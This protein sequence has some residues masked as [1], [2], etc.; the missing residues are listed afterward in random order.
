[1]GRCECLRRHWKLQLA[2][3]LL[4]LVHLRVWVSAAANVSPD[5][6]PLECSGT[7]QHSWLAPLDVQEGN[8]VRITLDTPVLLSAL[9]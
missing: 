1:M 5:T 9:R 7:P 3:C 2:C 6:D 4:P 8:V